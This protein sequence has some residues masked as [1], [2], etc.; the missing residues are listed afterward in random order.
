VSELYKQAMDIDRLNAAVNDIIAGASPA[1]PLAELLAEQIAD[2]FENGVRVGLNLRCNEVVEDVPQIENDHDVLS[3]IRH[4][5]PCL[6]QAQQVCF[7][8][9]PG[10]I[11]LPEAIADFGHKSYAAGFDKGYAEGWEDGT[12]EGWEE[13]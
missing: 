8:V 1:K 12:L 6:V 5:D 10:I 2:A 13:A 4:T 11:E 7:N 9:I 3:I